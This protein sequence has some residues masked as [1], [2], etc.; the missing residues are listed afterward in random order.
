[1]NINNL[2]INLVKIILF[3]IIISYTVSIFFIPESFVHGGSA[4]LTGRIS[5]TF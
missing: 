3:L 1:M 4:L 5:K 2:N